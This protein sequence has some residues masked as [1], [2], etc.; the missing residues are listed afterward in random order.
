MS[1]NDAKYDSV[2]KRVAAEAAALVVMAAGI[3]VVVAPLPYLDMWLHQALYAVPAGAP[4]PT[5]RLEL[6]KP[7]LG[8]FVFIFY[9]ILSF[10][11]VFAAWKATSEGLTS[12]MLNE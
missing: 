9:A 7:L 4:L 12:V 11:V 3:A 8:L 6:W 5:S 1:D 2:I 10:V